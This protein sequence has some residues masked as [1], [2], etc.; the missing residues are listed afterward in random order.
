MNILC[1]YFFFK[2]RPTFLYRQVFRAINI[3]VKMSPNDRKG[4]CKNATNGGLHGDVSLS[5]TLAFGQRGYCV[6]T[7]IFG[8]YNVTYRKMDILH[9]HKQLGISG[10][11]G[12]GHISCIASIQYLHVSGVVFT[13][14]GRST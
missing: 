1:K 14:G 3:L 5:P 9:G 2:M 6:S 11:Y 10:T 4:L 7:Y 12:L 13:K 8:T